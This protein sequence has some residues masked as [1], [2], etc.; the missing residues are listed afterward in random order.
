MSQNNE[1]SLDDF[2]EVGDDD[3]HRV[4]IKYYADLLLNRKQ[5]QCFTAQQIIKLLIWKNNKIKNEKLYIIGLNQVLIKK[6][7]N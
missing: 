1:F 3:S 7:I 2:L 5:L 6:N 4:S